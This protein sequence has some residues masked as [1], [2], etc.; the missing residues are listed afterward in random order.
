MS[1]VTNDY[2]RAVADEI[3][4]AAVALSTLAQLNGMVLTIDTKPLAPLAM[5]NYSIQIDIRLS[6]HA[7]RSAS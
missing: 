5:G 3:G 7:Y 1:P 2:T 6:H 4:K